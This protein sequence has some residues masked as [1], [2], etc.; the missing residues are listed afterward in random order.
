MTL[1]TEGAI[2]RA[3]SH[4]KHLDST[5][6]QDA[7]A[8]FIPCL[9]L[10]TLPAVLCLVFAGA[11]HN[12]QAQAVPT[13]IIRGS[14]SITAGGVNTQF[15]NFADNAIGGKIGLSYQIYPLLGFEFRG[16][17]YPIYAQFEQA[18]M[19]AGY[20]IGRRPFE[21]GSE[22]FFKQF[23]PYIYVGGGLSHAQDYLLSSGRKFLPTGYAWDPCWQGS[24]GLDRS[25]GWVS[26]RMF[27]ASYTTT[28][29]PRS[30]LRSVS[31]DTGLVFHL[32][33]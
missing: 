20:R 28:Y 25:L 33:R 31:L 7:G 13:R 17:I 11:L 2:Y 6:R 8:H 32:G 9:R 10:K 19:T 21:G 26:W 16:S 3:Q 12:A 1:V 29:T 14:I 30:A 22:Q 27:E 24:F 4:R 23:S 15:P 18:P 5:H